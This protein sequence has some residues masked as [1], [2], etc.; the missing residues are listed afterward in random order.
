MVPLSIYPLYKIIRLTT[1]D[2]GIK[3]IHVHA[4]LFSSVTTYSTCVKQLQTLILLVFPHTEIMGV[5]DILG[6][7]CIF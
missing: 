5:E 4:Y 7:V 1:D 3:S 6:L 2:L